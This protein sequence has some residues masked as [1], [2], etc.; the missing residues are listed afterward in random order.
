VKKRIGLIGTAV[1]GAALLIWFA[2][3]AAEVPVAPPGQQATG[4]GLASTPPTTFAILG[5]GLVALGVYAKRK[6]HKR[7]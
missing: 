3:S 4:T 7:T 1:T 5:A 6:N 2:S